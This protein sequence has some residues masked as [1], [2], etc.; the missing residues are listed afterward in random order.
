[1]NKE[2]VQ[3]ILQRLPKRQYVL[4]WSIVITV[5]LLSFGLCVYWNMVPSPIDISPWTYWVWW[6]VVPAWF[7]ATACIPDIG[8]PARQLLLSA[9]VANDP[10]A[11]YW[12]HSGPRF[13]P[14]PAVEDQCESL[15]IH[16]RNGAH[17]KV[18][19][20]PATMRSFVTWLRQANPAIH[21]GSFD[22]RT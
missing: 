5:G 1:M 13:D 9:I 19:L 4:R 8:L 2:E 16:L 17:L 12:V 7:V 3:H 21:C 11:V 20:P 15:V 22:Q 14:S 10:Q 18:K 6:F